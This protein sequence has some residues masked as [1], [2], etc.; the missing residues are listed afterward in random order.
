M[1]SEIQ[2]DARTRMTKSTESLID[3]LSKLR[4]GRAHPSL[5]DNLMVSYYGNPTPLNQVAA[6]SVETALMLAVKPWE[7]NMIP[8]I[9]KAIRTSDLGLNPATSSDVIRVPIPPLSE[10]RRKELIKKV[11]HEVEQ[12]KV[13][14]RNIRRDAN[15]HF[16]ELEK[17]KSISEDDKRRAEELVQKMT[18]DH[19]KKVDVIFE[20]KEKELLEI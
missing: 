11:K 4:A 13:A 2:N 16:E 6:V 8:H 1:I 5:L 14:I 20:R 7:K 17:S 3:D 18:D 9:E 10:E 19:V 12:S 15:K